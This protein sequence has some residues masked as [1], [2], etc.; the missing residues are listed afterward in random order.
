MR[1]QAAF[2]LHP[3]PKF[4]LSR[5]PGQ[6]VTRNQLPQ[7]VKLPQFL[8]RPLEEEQCGSEGFH[9][10]G[11]CVEGG[12]WGRS[13]IV[14]RT[15][16]KSHLLPAAHRAAL[17][18]VMEK[19]ASWT[20]LLSPR[21]RRMHLGERPTRGERQEKDGKNILNNWGHLIIGIN[22]IVLNHS[23]IH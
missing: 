19:S 11:G 13:V 6:P 3:Q 10:L 22:L 2:T 14:Q 4:H 7:L 1:A 5:V 9:S 17:M 23:G 8:T 15:L 21:W 18:A 16:L 20:V 12:E